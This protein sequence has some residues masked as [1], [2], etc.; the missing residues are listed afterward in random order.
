MKVEELHYELP[1]S[2][3]AQAA[4]EPRD[5]SRLLDTRDMTDHVFTDLP[6]LL[7]PGDLVVI[8]DTKVRRARLNGTKSKTGGSVELLLL[9]G[10]EDGTWSAM[11]RPARRITQGTV[12][13][14]GEVDLTVIDGP[15]DG[16][17]T[18]QIGSDDIEE[19]LERAGEVP[20][21][22]YFHGALD[23]DSRYQT[24]FARE[25]G[26]AAAPT[27]GLHF[28][29]RVVDGLGE[30]GISMA[31]VDLHVGIDTFRPIAVED[32]DDHRM[33]SEW[34]AVPEETATAV[35]EARRRGA[36]VVAV[37]TT[38][39]RALESL[40]RPDGRV[41]SGVIET[42]IFLRPGSRFTVVDLMVTNFH[43]PGS[44]LI[45]MIS[46]FMGERWRDAYRHALDSGYRFLSFG[47]A[48]LCERQR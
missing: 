16:L 45:A 47:D 26:S 2:A 39:T 31:R 7:E 40:G 29:P 9:G 19:L 28:T 43:V 10:S 20:L 37:G 30:S 23:E 46:G 41:E 12:I 48:M 27:A 42:D 25:P 6:A 24:I 18:L 21:P 17:V 11:I 22:P 1:E 5:S 3:I 32:T 8:N 4:I 33:H 34:C 36:R 44:T 14:V 13:E 38:T 35:E 15:R